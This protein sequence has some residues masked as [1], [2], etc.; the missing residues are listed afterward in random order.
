MLAADDPFVT[1]TTPN[2][3]ASEP[4]TNVGIFVIT[5][6]RDFDDPLDVRLRVSGAAGNGT[7]YEEIDSVVTIPAGKRNLRIR[8][9][10]LDDNDVEVTEGARLT[11]RTGED[12]R[13][14]DANRA[15]VKIA[16]D[17]VMSTPPPTVTV[18]ATDSS[19]AEQ[20]RATGTFIIRRAGDLNED[21]RVNLH[22]SS[23]AQNGV[24]FDE[25]ES[26]IIIEAG[27]DS[28]VVTIRPID[29]DLVEGT[30]T[31][32]LE[33]DSDDAYIIGAQKEDYV[34]IADNDQ[35]SNPSSTINWSS[36]AASPVR[37]FEAPS[38]VVNGRVYVFGGWRWDNTAQ[39]ERAQQRVDMYNPD[40]NTWTQRANLPTKLTHAALAVDGTKVYLIGGF[41]GDDPGVATDDIWIFDTVA[42]NWTKASFDLP[43]SR[44]AGGAAIID[45]NLHFFGG[46]DATRVND[47][48]K[49]WAIDL[50]NPGAGWDTLA[51]MPNAR[52]HF[53]TVE[54]NGKIYVFGGQHGH[55]TEE[56]PQDNT[57]HV[58]NP[59][60][61]S[62]SALRNLPATLSHAEPGIFVREGRIIIA[63]GM[64]G[65]E[66]RDPVD[67]VLEYN[68][69]TDTYRQLTPLPVALQAPVVQLVN[70]KLF[71]TGGNAA[72]GGEQSKSY[73]GTFV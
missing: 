23:S 63:G 60:A 42:N 41:V 20:G 17:D 6:D 48:N 68:P 49:H 56:R 12:Y 44:G 27:Q 50:D 65:T 28:V 2:R 67:D 18:T 9:T 52:H 7:D 8:L 45:G 24:D 32:E 29:D 69:E 14:G 34:S 26:S 35:S 16:D 5:R 19:A 73:I 22:L 15:T 21:L 37:R 39:V 57:A 62:W 66:E 43:E 46:S 61:N 55:D 38:A 3:T 58:Y 10:P 70:G 64:T 54:L 53:A 47:S 51:N 4:G 31:V 72:S 59:A 1:I 11:L 25:V 13:V 40:T 30:E 71:V 33:I 36:A